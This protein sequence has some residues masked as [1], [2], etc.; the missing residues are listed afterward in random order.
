MTRFPSSALEMYTGADHW[1]ISGNR[2][3]NK[4]RE[5]RSLV[6]L[7]ELVIGDS[8]GC[9]VTKRGKLEIF[10]NGESLGVGWGG[11]PADKLIWGFAD[12]Y[13]RTTEVRSNTVCGKL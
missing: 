3:Y 6:N 2:I 10:L 4:Q 1:T 11:L 8:V 7:D 5:K 9:L 13:G 12:L